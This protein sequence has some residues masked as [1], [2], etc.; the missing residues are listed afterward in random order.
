MTH[1][2]IDIEELRLSGRIPLLNPYTVDNKSYD[3]LLK[4][5]D[6]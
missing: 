2:V 3:I 6:A 1:K 4:G 5:G